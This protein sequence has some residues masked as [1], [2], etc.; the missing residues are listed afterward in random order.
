MEAPDVKNLIDE[1]IDKLSISYIV[2]QFVHCYRCKG[3]KSKY[4]IARIHGLGRIWQTALNITPKYLI[5]VLSE[6]YDKLS[7]D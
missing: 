7:T 4:T 5:E 2:P 3:S 6:R 1:I